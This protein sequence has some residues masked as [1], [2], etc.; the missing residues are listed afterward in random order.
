MVEFLARVPLE[1]HRRRRLPVRA[2][3]RIMSGMSR[4]EPNGLHQNEPEWELVTEDDIQALRDFGA[5]E[6]RGET[7]WFSQEE[8]EES[9]KGLL[10]EGK[11]AK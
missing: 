8:M 10:R 5:A 6:A 11:A 3:V 9:C 4:Q 7:E 2:E 1:L